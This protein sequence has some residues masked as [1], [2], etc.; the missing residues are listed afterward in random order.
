ML[1]YSKSSVAWETLYIYFQH[2]LGVHSQCLVAN[3]SALSPL[4]GNHRETLIPPL[5]AP[6]LIPSTLP[7]ISSTANP[8][9]DL[10]SGAEKWSF[11]PRVPQTTFW[12][13]KTG[14]KYL[15][16]P[17]SGIDF[18]CDTPK[19]LKRSPQKV[20]FSRSTV[21]SSCRGYANHLGQSKLSN[22][23]PL[24]HYGMVRIPP[25]SGSKYSLSH[26]NCG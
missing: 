5:L 3:W 13:V 23:I 1:P 7:G 16:V 24:M 9:K 25:M 21:G 10:P 15:M 20:K 6:H 17:S 22:T 26:S 8:S 14:V 11:G 12:R 2:F 4:S 19:T 18:S